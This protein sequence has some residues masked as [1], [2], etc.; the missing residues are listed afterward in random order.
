[1]CERAAKLREGLTDDQGNNV[2]SNLACKAFALQS[3]DPKSAAQ[4]WKKALDM[5]P[6]ALPAQRGRMAFA[7]AQALQRIH[8]PRDEIERRAREARDAYAKFGDFA[9]KVTEIDA[10]LKALP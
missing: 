4:L 6:A 7:L 10:W 8:A 2:R 5:K 9:D 3:T 1:M